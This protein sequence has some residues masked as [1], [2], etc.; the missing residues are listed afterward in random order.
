MRLE[1]LGQIFEKWRCG[2]QQGCRAR[3]RRGGSPAVGQA[4]LFL[5]TGA[6]HLGGIK[7]RGHALSSPQVKKVEGE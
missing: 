6:N 7:V 5:L 1:H 2:A 4:N 3:G